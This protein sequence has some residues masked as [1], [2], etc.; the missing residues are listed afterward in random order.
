ML[1]G[2]RQ[3]PSL[4]A[5]AAP[6]SLW[7]ANAVEAGGVIRPVGNV[8]IERAVGEVDALQ[9]NPAWI[10]QVRRSFQDD[11]DA[12]GSGDVESESARP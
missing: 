11:G 5:E 9:E 8:E 2:S 10:D 1:A 7:R 12:R 3:E 6:P 4:S